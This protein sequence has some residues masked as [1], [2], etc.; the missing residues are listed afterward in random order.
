VSRNFS[1]LVDLSGLT[2]GE[3]ERL[4]RVHELLVVAG[5]PPELPGAL[6]RPPT[7][8]APAGVVPIESRRRRRGVVA[9]LIAAALTALAF[10]GG[11]VLGDRTESSGAMADAVR[12]LPLQGLG[13]SAVGSVRVGETES[14]GN[15][16]IELEVSGLPKQAGERDYYELFVW[17][18]GKPSYPC[19]GFKMRDDTTKVR[20]SVPYEFDDSTRLV[21]TAIEP[22]KVRWPGKVV[23]STSV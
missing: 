18:R 21:V 10:A 9:G 15:V 3:R 11:Y 6:Q 2:E 16:P 19:G 1:D 7:H 17:R 23:M 20:F 13:G 22:G 14:G 8:P 12:V 5:P 4:E